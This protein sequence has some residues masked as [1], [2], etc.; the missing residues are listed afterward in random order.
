M[1]LGGKPYTEIF[2][3]R[4]K[5]LRTFEIDSQDQEYEWHRDAEDRIVEVL[6]GLGWLFQKDNCLPIKIFPGDKI[7][8]Q[9]NEWHRI[10]KGKDNLKVII[11]KC[12]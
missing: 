7:E 11:E 3:E 4:N 6:S 12:I 2:L 1:S 8:I 9:K 5:I 10:I